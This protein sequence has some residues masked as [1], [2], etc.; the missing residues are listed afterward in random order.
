MAGR[1]SGC[2]L[3]DSTKKV[4]AHVVTCRDYIRLHNSAPDQCL[5]PETEYRRH[6]AADTFEARAARRDARLQERFAELER[7]HARQVARWRTPKSILDD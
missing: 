5:D 4:T 1:C 6:R 7:L 3:T 2:G